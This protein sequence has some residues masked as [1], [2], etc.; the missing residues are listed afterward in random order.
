MTGEKIMA[1][2]KFNCIGCNGELTAPGVLL[3]AFIR[4]DN[5]NTKQQVPFAEDNSEEVSFTCISCDLKIAVPKSLIGK[6]IR[7][8][9]N[10][11]IIGPEPGQDVVMAPEKQENKNL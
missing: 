10:A 1:E 5:C 6:H 7:C 2:V 4:C 3:G 11:R 9:C 8:E